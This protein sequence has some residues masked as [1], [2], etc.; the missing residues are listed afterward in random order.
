MLDTSA[1]DTV[2]ARPGERWIEVTT[3]DG[4][5]PYR[6]LVREE[7]P[8]GLV[9]LFPRNV[10]QRLVDDLGA[11]LDI[12]GGLAW[13]TDG[14]TVLITTHADDDRPRRVRPDERSLYDLD[15]DC[16]TP[17]D[18]E[19][20]EAHWESTAMRVTYAEPTPDTADDADD[21]AAAEAEAAWEA[22]IGRRERALDEALDALDREGFRV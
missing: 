1:S 19:C 17:A 7:F 5:G 16:F 4:D 15:L 11:H 2:P 9:P 8:R 21:A 6:A 22:E 12:Y 20:A 3:P 13:D 18:P 10:M 14:T